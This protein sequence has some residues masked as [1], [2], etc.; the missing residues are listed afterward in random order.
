MLEA[1]PDYYKE[2]H[3]IAGACRHSCCIGW[4][5]DIDSEMADCYRNLSGELG[6]R[7]R[8]C[9]AWE[10]TPHFILDEKERCPFLNKENLCDVIL[11]LGEEYICGICTDHPR[12][13]NELPGRL[14]V[15]LGLCC[16]EAA[17]LII[18][19]NVPMTLEIQGEEETEDELVELRDHVITMLQDRSKTVSERL[20]DVLLLCGIS[21]PDWT[22]GEWAQ[23]LL[24]LERLTEEWTTL[25]ISL[26]DGWN[27]A[28]FQG[29]DQYMEERQMEYE[30][31]VVYLI[32]RHMANGFDRWEAAARACFAAFG[33]FLLRGMGAV[34]WTGTKQFTQKQQIELARLFSSELEYS[35]ENLNA[36]LD[37]MYE[38]M[39]E[40]SFGINA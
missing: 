35:Q 28:D 36:I 5:I 27:N 14:E 3:C 25:L 2:F 37:I 29:F 16:E 22:L 10:E 17:R 11:E 39:P 20:N 13:R 32:Y 9:I 21:L 7:L 23:K 8:R 6:E 33:Y 34:L 1:V 30:Q 19:R 15:G 31:F 24:E 40:E 12:F 38:N 4:E 26:R 18:S